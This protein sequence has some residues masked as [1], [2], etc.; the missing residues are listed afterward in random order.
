MTPFMMNENG[1]GANKKPITDFTILQILKNDQKENGD[2][3]IRNKNTNTHPHHHPHPPTLNKVL[4]NPWIPLKSHSFNPSMHQRKLNFNS[5]FPL[6]NS[7][8]FNY[9]LPILH[10]TVAPI[11][12]Q[13]IE[14]LQKP[15][16]TATTQHHTSI[17]NHF[18][19]IATNGLNVT[20]QHVK[21]TIVNTNHNNNHQLH[22]PHH[23]NINSTSV[24]DTKVSLPKLNVYDRNNKSCDTQLLSEDIKVVENDNNNNGNIIGCTS[25]TTICENKC[26]I[27]LKVLQSSELLDVRTQKNIYLLKWKFSKKKIYYH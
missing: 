14:N 13:Y 15:A 18:Y 27:C 26:T 8:F 24:L 5:Q 20:S 16:A 17:H 6:P 19:S 4:Q 23:Q 2:L 25:P 9:S 12:D 11:N 1:N 3:Q 22:H 10:P 7:S 21:N